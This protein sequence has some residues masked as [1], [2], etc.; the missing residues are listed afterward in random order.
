LWGWAR[1]RFGTPA[2]FAQRFFVT[3][4][5]P[6]AF[7]ADSGANLTPDKLPKADT[8]PLF[9]ICD[10]LLRQV[11]AV[12]QPRWVVGVGAFA[13]QRVRG[14]VDGDGPQVGRMPH[15][16]PASPAANQGWDRLADAA[17]SKLGIAV[18]G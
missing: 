9:T 1:Q 12:V 15:P 6:L 5:C 14:V 2:A 7:V 3:N 11:I 16:S 8:A 13:E 10:R 18:G 4:Y 17:L